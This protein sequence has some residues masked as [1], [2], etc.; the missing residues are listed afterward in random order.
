MRGGSFLG[1]AHTNKRSDK[2]G[3]PIFGGTSDI[4]DDFDCAYTI[5]EVANR[6]SGTERVVQFDCIKSR[7]NVAQ[8]VAYSYSIEPTLPYAARVES[9]HVVDGT[10]LAN[11]RAQKQ[12]EQDRELIS[13][14]EA[15]IRDGPPKTK[16]ELQKEVAIQTR[17]GRHTIGTLLDKYTGEDPDKHRWYF[18]VGARGA[19]GY[20]LIGTP[21]NGP[22]IDPGDTF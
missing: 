21:V 5:V 16:T 10:E 20:R 22:I 7:G 6:S 9:V 13:V 1:L 14:I 15:C 11:I 3:K 19:R 4:L 8:Q 2:D 17:T 12:I 18:D